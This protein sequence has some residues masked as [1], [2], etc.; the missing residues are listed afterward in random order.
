[1][2]AAPR[3]ELY[4][5]DRTR[6]KSHNLYRERQALGDRMIQQLRAGERMSPTQAAPKPAVESI[7]T[8]GAPG[9]ARL[10]R[11]VRG[12][13]RGSRTGLADPK[14]KIDL[15]N[16][17]GEATELTKEVDEH[18]RPPFARITAILN[19]IVAQDP[20]VIDAW[21]ML[22]TQHMAHDDLEAAVGYFK[23]TL[24]LKPDYDLPFS[25]S[26]RPTGAWGTTM[27]RWP[28]SSIT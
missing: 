18:G 3:P 15:F 11:H 27:R 22:G 20:Q 19:G 17:L 13:R 24:E 25:I 6:R 12:H 10:R 9:G 2:I 4:D 7:R 21:F 16:K 5:A 1:M 26:R 23:H 14:D 28:D 8:R